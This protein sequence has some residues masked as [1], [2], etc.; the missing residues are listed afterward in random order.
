M[1]NRVLLATMLALTGATLILSVHY[2]GIATLESFLYYKAI[3]EAYAATQPV[4]AKVLF[5]SIYALES[6]LA[7]PLSGLLTVIGGYLFGFVAGT[8]C[9][10]LGATTGAI[11]LFLV[12]RFLLR[13]YLESLYAHRLPSIRMELEEYGGWYLVALR[14]MPM[15]PFFLV[16]ILAGLS[17]VPL[18]T[19]IIATVIGIIPSTLLFSFAGKELTELHSVGD[20]LTPPVIGAFLLMALA[21]LS[22]MLIKRYLW[23][24]SSS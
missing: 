23:R 4:Q 1:N 24:R 6:S 17:P 11:F 16:N 8:I 10:I 18:P 20:I 15:M 7:L 13:D 5:V 14:L 22:P 19:F 12:T 21:A 3:I 2:S 9:T